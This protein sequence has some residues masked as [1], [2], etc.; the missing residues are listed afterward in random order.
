MTN[1][2]PPDGTAMFSRPEYRK[3]MTGHVVAV[4]IAVK[5]FEM[6]MPNPVA[7]MRPKMPA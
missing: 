1:F 3:A 4:E 5:A 6:T 7:P 2:D